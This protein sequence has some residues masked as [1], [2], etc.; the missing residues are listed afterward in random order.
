MMNPRRVLRDIAVASVSSVLL[1]LSYH[2]ADLSFFSWFAL[3]PWFYTLVGCSPRRAALVSFCAGFLF[4]LAGLWWISIVTFIG[5][6]VACVILSCFTALF[7]FLA[8][9]AVQR[10][11]VPVIVAFPI[12]W[13]ALEYARSNFFFLSFPWL[14]LAHSQYANIKLIQVCDI[15]GVFGLS[16]VI[17]FANTLIALFAHYVITRTGSLPRLAVTT[18]V[19]AALILLSLL[20]GNYRIHSVKLQ[21]GPR[22]FIVQGNVPQD[23]KEESLRNPGESAEKIISDHLSLTAPAL[24][25]KVDLIVWPETMYPKSLLLSGDDLLLFSQIAKDSGASMLVGTQHCEVDGSKTRTYNSAVFIRAD[26][27]VGG[28]YDKMFLVP[29]GEYIPL[30]NTLPLLGY[31]ISKLYPYEY[32][33]LSEGEEMKIFPLNGRHSFACV[34]CFELSFDWLVQKA[35]LR[36]AQFIVN[37]SNDA[38]FLGDKWWQGSAELD[39]ARSHAAFRAVENRIPIVR[40]VNRGISCIA[41]PLGRIKD[42]DVKGERK[43]VEGTFTATF[44][45]CAESPPFLTLGN[46]FACACLLTAFAV[47]AIS[48]IL[49]F[50]RRKHTSFALTEKQNPL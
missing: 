5:L 23:L 22:V 2:P 34:I 19:F 31:A 10:L 27:S 17:A 14:L 20:Y 41:D 39:L 50:R 38:W 36:G 35:R 8:S 49:H 25:E 18:A 12:L 48:L 15:L 47:A 13:V 40:A 43:N 4:F 1:F 6:V 21:E 11:R 7:G 26:G 45:L 33:S 30:E 42:F 28:R 24:S 3:V 37:V 46:L 44:S 32:E 16:A 29:V 9:C